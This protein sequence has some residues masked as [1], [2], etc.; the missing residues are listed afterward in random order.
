MMKKLMSL[1]MHQREVPAWWFT[2]GFYYYS[3]STLALC[4]VG[5]AYFVYLAVS[6][7]SWES[8]MVGAIF[9]PVSIIVGLDKLI[10]TP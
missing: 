3:L 4:F 10:F 9:F 2:L 7:K 5:G 8:L 1:L 6:Q